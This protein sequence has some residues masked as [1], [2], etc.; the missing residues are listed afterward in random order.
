MCISVII[1]TKGDHEGIVQTYYIDISLITTLVCPFG[2][3][4][5]NLMFLEV[6]S[7]PQKVLH[8]IGVINLL[9]QF[10]LI[11]KVYTLVKIL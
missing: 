5:A 11:S 10:V 3:T 1:Y 2:G 9:I 8:Y 6:F 7:T 4:F